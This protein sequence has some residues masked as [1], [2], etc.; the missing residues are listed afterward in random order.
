MLHAVAPKMARPLRRTHVFLGRSARHTRCFDAPRRSLVS[1]ARLNSEVDRGHADRAHLSRLSLRTRRRQPTRAN[2]TRR[3]ACHSKASNASRVLG[4][5]HRRE[6]RIPSNASGS[7]RSDPGVVD[8]PGETLLEPY[9]RRCR[10]LLG[11]STG[12]PATRAVAAGVS[13]YEPA[14]TSGIFG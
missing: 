6:V 3:C 12:V 9:G 1:A 5:R 11:T 13:P 4:D 2:G 10:A 8:V 7:F 14:P